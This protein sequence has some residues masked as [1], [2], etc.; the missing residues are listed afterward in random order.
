MD[1]ITLKIRGNYVV[2][3]VKEILISSES[4]V[5]K[6]PTSTKYGTFTHPNSNEPCAYG[7]IA[8][9]SDLSKVWQLGLDDAWH[10]V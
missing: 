3:D 4:D 7:S 9:L 2:P 10:E 8:Y 6:L 1:A 5:S